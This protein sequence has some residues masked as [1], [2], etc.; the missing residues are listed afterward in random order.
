MSGENTAVSSRV[1]RA[2]TARQDERSARISRISARRAPT[3]HIQGEQHHR[4]KLTD[5]EVAEMRELHEQAEIGYKTLGKMF[6]C[7][8][9]TARNICQYLTR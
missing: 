1:Q 2:P 9:G 3:G 7:P 4:A 6:N 8:K 5:A